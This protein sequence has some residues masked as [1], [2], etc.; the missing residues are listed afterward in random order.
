LRFLGNL[1]GIEGLDK[2]ATTAHEAGK[3]MRYLI[4]KYIEEGKKMREETA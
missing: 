1:H 2:N 4:N 3:T